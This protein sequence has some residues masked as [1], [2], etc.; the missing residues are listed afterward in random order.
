M[1]VPQVGVVLLALSLSAGS[2]AAQSAPPL[3]PR[4]QLTTSDQN[5][6]WDVRL[7]RLSGDTLIVQQHDS[8]I[9]VPLAGIAEL[10]LLPETILQVGDGHHSAISALAGDNPDVY[11]LAPLDLAGRKATIQTILARLSPS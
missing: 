2:L 7:E 9:G 3:P 5:Y 1:R 6:I 4:W 10:R 8:L 11:D